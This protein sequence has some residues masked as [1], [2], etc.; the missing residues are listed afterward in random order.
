MSYFDYHCPNCQHRYSAHSTTVGGV[1]NC[2]KCGQKYIAGEEPKPLFSLN[3]EDE[4]ENTGE[5]ENFEGVTNDPS[6]SS[7]FIDSFFPLKNPNLNKKYPTLRT[8]AGFYKFLTYGMVVITIGFFILGLMYINDNERDLGTILMLG[9]V[10]VGSITVITLLATS[11]GI[12]LF[13]NMANDLS[14]VKMSLDDQ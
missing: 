3:S 6:T 10:V 8:I 2:P 12:I 1:S 7:T 4:S 11:E 9:S 5:N 13:V 14:E